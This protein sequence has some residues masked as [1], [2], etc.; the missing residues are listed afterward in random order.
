VVT[1]AADPT[2][3]RELGARLQRNRLTKP[4]FD[5]ASQAR[6]VEAAYGL[7]YERLQR[8]LAPQY[9]EISS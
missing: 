1:L 4:L 6:H 3:L 2:R 5:C 7:M 8:G 9:L